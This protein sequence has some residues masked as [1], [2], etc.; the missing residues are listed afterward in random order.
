MNAL[1][2][3][4]G[5]GLR[6]VADVL[7][8]TNVTKRFGQFVAVARLSLRV[9][10]GQI[11]G[12]LGPNGAGKTTTIRMIM[13]ITY[14]DSGTIEVLGHP[15]AL[16]V[17]DRIGYLPEERGLYRKMTVEQTLRYFG[18]LKGME[19][20]NL[21]RRIGELLESVG[22]ASWRKKTVESLSKGMQ[23]KLQFVTTVLH[24][25]EL[26]VL[27][28]PFSGL[29]P[30]NRDMLENL[31]IDLKRR[32]KTVLFSTHQMEQAERLCDRLV[33]INRGRVLISG[34]IDEIR[35][36][37]ASRKLELSGDGDFSTLSSLPGVADAHITVGGAWLELAVGA[38]ANALVKLA[39]DR[40][41][42]T[43]FEIARPTLQEIFVT[44]VGDDGTRDATTGTQ[45]DHASAARRAS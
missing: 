19:S 4:P 12:F 8:L 10:S 27:D 44:L 13:S 35:S 6:A 28:E 43:R 40:V 22:L 17:K 31:M 1:E 24:D 41:R 30:L 14:P 29:D 38:D 20:T 32:G 36:Q 3:P 15:R 25:P 5:S 26:V 33:L 9:P 37:F 45:Q 7:T 18:K 39:L 16:E 23:Q 11:M 42:L 34:T 2:S 21:E